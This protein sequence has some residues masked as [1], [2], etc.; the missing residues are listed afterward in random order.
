MDDSL[1]KRVEIALKQMS[2]PSTPAPSIFEVQNL[3]SELE[4]QQPEKPEMMTMPTEVLRK[5]LREMKADGTTRAMFEEHK[6]RR[7][8]ALAK[9]LAETGDQHRRD[10]FMMLGE[11]M[12]SEW[13]PGVPSFNDR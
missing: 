12:Q 7:I 6:T 10:V 13:V 11:V 8:E 3:I 1:K 4:E 9:L 5:I 2:D